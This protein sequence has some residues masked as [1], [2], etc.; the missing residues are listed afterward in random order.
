MSFISDNDTVNRLVNTKMNQES[1]LKNLEGLRNTL[2]IDDKE[3]EDIIKKLKQNSILE[4]EIDFQLSYN[5]MKRTDIQ[6]IDDTEF[7]LEGDSKE[8]LIDLN[9]LRGFQSLKY[10]W[11]FFKLNKIELQAKVTRET[12]GLGFF[13]C[14]YCPP[15]YYMAHYTPFLSKSCESNNQTL[16]YSISKPYYVVRN[17]FHGRIDLN[18]PNYLQ[19][20]KQNTVVSSSLQDNIFVSSFNYDITFL[21][22]G[23]FIFRSEESKN[24]KARL[25]YS[26]TFYTFGDPEN[27]YGIDEHEPVA[28]FDPNNPL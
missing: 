3:R 4:K 15:C 28:P 27:Q 25:I 14:Q 9:K 11:L 2:S 23:S 10:K 6:I 26:F 16:N 7:R 13:Q 18:D 24:L 12:D 22:Y 21:D 20:V 19:I 8:I 1:I 5:D 17:A